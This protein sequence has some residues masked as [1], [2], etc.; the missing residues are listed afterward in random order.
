ME[1]ITLQGKNQTRPEYPIWSIT[2]KQPDWLRYYLM[3]V[4]ETVKQALHS[5]RS[6][7]CSQE[8]NLSHL[9]QGMELLTPWIKH[10]MQVVS[11]Q[12][13]TQLFTTHYLRQEVTALEE[14]HLRSTPNL[15]TCTPWCN[16]QGI[17]TATLFPKLPQR[18]EEWLSQI[19][20]EG[21]LQV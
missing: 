15:M 19:S 21:L 12:Y 7:R 10:S 4:R 9:V 11:N 20:K 3:R 8:E 18:L 17:C 13:I 16:L 2:L 5:L 14:V 1:A 6:L